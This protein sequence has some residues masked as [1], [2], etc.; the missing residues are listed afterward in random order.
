M[1]STLKGRMGTVRIG[2]GKEWKG[3]SE[4]VKVLDRMRGE[5]KGKEEKESK[6]SERKEL[7]KRE[8]K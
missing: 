1:G 2:Y 6:G 7:Y 8:G 4:G 5:G 3:Y